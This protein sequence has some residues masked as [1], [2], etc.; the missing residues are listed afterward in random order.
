MLGVGFDAVTLDSAAD[1]IINHIK[2]GASLASVFTPNADIV[3]KCHRD[4]SGALK[5]LFDSASLSVPDGIGIIK[6]SKLL[7]TPLPERVAGIELGERLI[8]S[9]AEEGIPVFFLGGEK[10][11][12]GDAAESMKKRHPSLTVAGTHH[13]YFDRTGHENDSVISLIEGSGA[14]LLF[15]C[16]GAPAQ[17][18]WILDHSEELSSAGI[19]CAL[20]LGGSLDVWSGRVRRVPRFFR[21]LGLEWLVR[22]LTPSRYRRIGNVFRF[23]FDV[24]REK[25]ARKQKLRP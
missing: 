25:L 15:V 5:V 20:G 14:K 16:F 23:V 6:A 17:E 8:A 10:G 2:T 19:K 18:K 7:G 24:F 22:S 4:R 13:G 12:A 11:V 3:E 9:A 21:L 1:L